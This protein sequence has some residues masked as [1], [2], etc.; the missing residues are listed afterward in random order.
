M[1]SSALLFLVLM[2]LFLVQFNYVQNSALN[3]F[4]PKSFVIS[5][6]LAIGTSI[7]FF[8]ADKHIQS[9]KVSK[10]SRFLFLGLILGFSFIVAQVNG[11]YELYTHGMSFPNLNV[12]AS[13]LYVIS[14]VH[15]VHVLL[16]IV[17]HCIFMV[18]FYRN[19]HDIV[20]E[21]LYVTNPFQVKKFELICHLWH[22]IDA[23]WI[24]LFILFL[25]KSSIP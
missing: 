21:L 20:S 10:A 24:I 4:M 25:I 3:F 14:G 11:W 16:A 13:Y 8:F 12:A 19:T 7:V 15:L 22:Y 1:A 18:K 2:T 23:V 17:L 5:T 6:L 9:D